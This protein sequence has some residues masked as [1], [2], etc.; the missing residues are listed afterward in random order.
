MEKK[1]TESASINS[2]SEVNHQNPQSD[3]LAFEN[4]S[5]WEKERIQSEKR[6]L[7]NDEAARGKDSMSENEDPNSIKEILVRAYIFWILRIAW[8][9]Q[10]SDRNRHRAVSEY[11]LRDPEL[12]AYWKRARAAVLNADHNFSNGAL[13]LEQGLIHKFGIGGQIDLNQAN[14]LFCRVWSK[15]KARL[16]EMDLPK[17][18]DDEVEMRDFTLWCLALRRTMHEL[19][20]LD[21]AT[22]DDYIAYTQALIKTV[23]TL[24]KEQG[25][26]LKDTNS[27]DEVLDSVQEKHGNLLLTLGEVYEHGFVQGC[28]NPLERALRYYEQADLCGQ[29]VGWTL[30]RHMR[31]ECCAKA[32]D[33]YKAGAIPLDELEA[34]VRRLV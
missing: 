2:Q 9:L 25:E 16:E 33:E 24:V 22:K 26:L 7:L 19:Y 10:G 5:D 20:D 6:L 27:T 3:P 23:E 31:R 30:A 14:S 15:H 8:R 11:L 21:F 28:E 34:K 1:N 12:Q 4:L 18:Y 17:I 13:L 29:H 32:F